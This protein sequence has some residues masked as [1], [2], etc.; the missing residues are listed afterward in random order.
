MKKHRTTLVLSVLLLIGFCLALALI[1]LGSGLTLWVGW[2]QTP[3]VTAKPRPTPRPVVFV[4]PTVTSTPAI[5][6]VTPV[7]P[8]GLASPPPLSSTV[9]APAFTPTLISTPLPVVT[10]IATPTPTPTFLPPSP[11]PLPPTATPTPTPSPPPTDTP[12]PTNTP[13]PALIFTASEVEQFPTNH[14]NFD[15]YIAVTDTNN[16]PLGGYRLVG[17]HSDGLQAESGLSANRWTENSGAMHYK[18]G[19]IKYQVPDS[20]GGVWTLQL[21]NEVGQPVALPLETSFDPAN[22]TWYFVLYRLGE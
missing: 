4:L 1:S 2:Q 17:H 20:P 18:A 3:E 10:E 5:L 21:V 9:S 11:T 16:T 14:L 19:N 22:P 7:I 15:V 6:N 8:M 12:T 13:T